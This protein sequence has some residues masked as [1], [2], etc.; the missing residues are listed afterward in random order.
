MSYSDSPEY[1]HFRSNFALKQI[2]VDE[3]DPDK[4]WKIFD[5]GPKESRK[6]PLVCLPP[7]SGTADCFFRLCLSLSNKGNNVK[8][9][10]VR[11]QVFFQNH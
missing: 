10:L 5:C 8:N 4:V 2:A 3:K 11:G 9:M 1:R 7:V 6:C